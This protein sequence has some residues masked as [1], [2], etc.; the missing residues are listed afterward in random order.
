[1]I[2]GT[3]LLRELDF[4]KH[5]LR[6]GLHPTKY[7]MLLFGLAMVIV[8]LWKPRGFVGSREPTA[9]LM[10]EKRL[11]VP[12]PRKDTADERETHMSK[13]ILQVEHLSM[14]FGGLSPSTTSPSRPSAATSPR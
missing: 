8:M 9:F 6:A 1:M 2:G 12:S 14:R 5:D 10:N 13:P 3:E 4:L 11:A 7:R